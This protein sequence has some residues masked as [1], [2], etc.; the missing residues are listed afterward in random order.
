M[1][2]LKDLPNHVDSRGSIQAIMEDCRNWVGSI[3]FITSNPNTER[4]SHY[5]LGDEGHH[6]LITEG[7]IWI[8]ERP[9]GSLGCPT[10]MV[11]K[12]GDLHWTGPNI[13]HTMFFPVKNS[14]YCFSVLPRNQKS[15][16]ENTVRIPRSLK[17]IYDS[18]PYQN[19]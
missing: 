5:H 15:Y 2:N 1:T 6:I 10:K 3:S 13:E 18:Y 19:G 11:L 8:Y 7:E 9:V 14:F 4:A 17:D 16:E 12:V